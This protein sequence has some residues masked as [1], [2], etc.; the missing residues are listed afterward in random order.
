MMIIGIEIDNQRLTVYDRINT[1]TCFK[2]FMNYCID[3]YPVR[4]RASMLLREHFKLDSQDPGFGRDIE[5]KRIVGHNLL[6]YSTHS[7]TKDKIRYMTEI[8]DILGI[9]LVLIS[10]ED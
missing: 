3:N 2:T 5:Y 10:D 6:F 4:I 1:T 8:A 7:G 9:H